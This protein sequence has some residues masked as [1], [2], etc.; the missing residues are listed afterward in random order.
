MTTLK[1][2]PYYPIQTDADVKEVLSRIANIRKDDITQIQNLQNI[3][4]GGRKVG[5]IPANSG[6]VAVTDRLGDISFDNSNMY[7]L[8]NSGAPAWIKYSGSVF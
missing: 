2:Y 6:D 5:K 8:Q 3:F 4:V 7:V 1:D